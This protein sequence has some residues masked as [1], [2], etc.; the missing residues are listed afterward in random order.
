M[1]FKE[2]SRNGNI[3]DVFVCH[4]TL[5]AQQIL[6]HWREAGYRAETINARQNSGCQSAFS[7]EPYGFEDEDTIA[8]TFG[9]RSFSGADLLPFPRSHN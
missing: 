9:E 6:L 2:I 1:S 3:A 7:R 8:F 4:P 5:G